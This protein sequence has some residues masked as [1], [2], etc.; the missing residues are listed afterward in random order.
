MTNS[1]RTREWQRQHPEKVAAIRQRYLLAKKAR[2][3]NSLVDFR[4][5]KFKTSSSAIAAFCRR[6]CRSGYCHGGGVFLRAT[7]F[8]EQSKCPLFAFRNGDPRAIGRGLVENNIRHY[9]ENTQVQ[10]RGPK[11]TQ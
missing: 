6:R 4:R 9:H 7:L 10:G 5:S 3:E 8:C 2:Q 1:E 11:E